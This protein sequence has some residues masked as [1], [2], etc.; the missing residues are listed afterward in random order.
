MQKSKPPAT[1][2]VARIHKAPIHQ[3]DPLWLPWTVREEHGGLPAVPHD[4]SRPYGIGIEGS[5]GTPQ[6]S[7]AHGN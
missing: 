5:G 7:E 3:T 4:M 1:A 2:T 6:M